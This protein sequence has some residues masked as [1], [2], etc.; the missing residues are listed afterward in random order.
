LIRTKIMKNVF[1]RLGRGERAGAALLMGGNAGDPA[2]AMKRAERSLNEQGA[3]IISASST[4]KTSPVGVTDQPDFLN[5]AYLIR[6]ALSPFELLTLCLQIEAS[7]GRTRPEDGS[8][9]PR[10]I[11]IDVLDY[12]GLVFLSP[13]LS[14]PH[15]RLHLRRFA[16]V[17]LMEIA[18]QWRHPVFNKTCAELL[19]ALPYADKVEKI[20]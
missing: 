15:P 8:K 18:P 12:D 14:L 10:E 6:S 4:Y 20:D 2:A 11:D 13:A 9:A 17:P 16:L 19:A 3:E 5:R 1:T 7:L